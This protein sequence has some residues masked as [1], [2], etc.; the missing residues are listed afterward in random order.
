M[1]VQV[2]LALYLTTATQSQNVPYDFVAIIAGID[3]VPVLI[4]PRALL[5]CCNDSIP[6]TDHIRQ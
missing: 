4:F 3:S 2:L 5:V 1:H 6:S